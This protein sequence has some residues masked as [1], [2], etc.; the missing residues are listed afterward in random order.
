MTREELDAKV[1]SGEA[2]WDG[3]LYCYWIGEECYNTSGQK[4][5]QL[6]GEDY[7]DGAW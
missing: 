7:G 5:R 4:L 2:Q 1:E 3:S 6:A